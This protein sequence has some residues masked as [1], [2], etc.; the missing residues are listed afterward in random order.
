VAAPS[1]PRASVVVAARNAAGAIG[2]CLASLAA[3]DYPRVEVIVADDGSTDETAEVA[4][5]AG[6]TVVAGEGLGPAA[7]RNAGVR[8][9]SGEIVAFTDA[10]CTV[11]PSWLRELA[12]TLTAVNAA[13]AG[14]PQRNVFANPSWAP[15]IEAFFRASSAVAEYTRS[16]GE[17][18]AVP[19]NASCSSAYWRGDFLAVGGF[20]PGLWPGEDV[21]LDYRL[22]RIGR[23][24]FFVP[25]AVVVHH[26]PGGLRW[27]VSMMRRYG[28]GQ[29]VLARRHGPF[30][31]IDAVP[32]AAALAIVAQVA[33]AWP[34]ARP[35]TL[36]IDAAA[37]VA[38]CAV[39]VRRAPV[40]VWPAL[41]FCATIGAAAWVAGYAAGIRDGART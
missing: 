2:D 7:A 27:F 10:D 4:R 8:A 12:S 38:L 30:R 13:S 25:G 33:L 6:A 22:R 23:P 18:R 19:H 1:L 31:A 40:R 39:L 35:W 16:H 37:V 17:A 21:D 14:G 20:T 36:A 28:H 11:E 5:R 32:V 41:V 24:A 26:R 3:L 9:S 15:A 34:A 29:G